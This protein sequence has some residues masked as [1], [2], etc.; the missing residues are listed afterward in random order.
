MK[1]NFEKGKAGQILA[2]RER[3]LITKRNTKQEFKLPTDII[4][5]A[6]WT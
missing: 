1:I 4:V 3:D 2:K 6:L 5:K